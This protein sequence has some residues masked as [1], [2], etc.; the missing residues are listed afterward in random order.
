L[1]AYLLTIRMS[2]VPVKPC[3]PSVEPVSVASAES[4]S[5]YASSSAVASH[6]PA[7]SR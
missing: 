1:K 7:L 4:L 3:P 2:P 6:T 5:G